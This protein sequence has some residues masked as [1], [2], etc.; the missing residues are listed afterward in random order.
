MLRWWLDLLSLFRLL[1]EAWVVLGRWLMLGDL[2]RDTVTSRPEPLDLAEG[3]EA[4]DTDEA[5]SEDTVTESRLAPSGRAAILASSSC[6]C[7]KAF[8]KAAFNLFVCSALRAFLTLDVTHCSQITL[9]PPFPENI[10]LL[11]FLLSIYGYKN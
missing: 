7:C 1:E 8:T 10:I 9:P 11:E 4:G 3:V 6:S 2:D 5:V